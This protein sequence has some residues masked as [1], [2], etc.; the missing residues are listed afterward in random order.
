MGCMVKNMDN[1]EELDK[2]EA[3]VKILSDVVPSEHW[4]ETAKKI[5]DA[6]EFVKG[7]SDKIIKIFKDASFTVLEFN[8]GDT[9][10]TLFRSAQV[11]GLFN[12]KYGAYYIG[13]DLKAQEH[14][15]DYRLH[16]AIDI[17]YKFLEKD[18]VE[19]AI[20]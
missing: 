18:K 9:Y 12:I 4:I 10:A 13:A 19:Y 14:R 6:R 1:P 5:E 8:K 20:F 7:D 2:F 17:L 15:I 16:Q 11:E 3:L